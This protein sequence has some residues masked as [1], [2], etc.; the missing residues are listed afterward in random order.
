MQEEI[1]SVENLDIDDI[2]VQMDEVLDDLIQV[3]ERDG[4]NVVENRGNNRNNERAIQNNEDGDAGGNNAEDGDE[5]RNS[6]EDGV[7]SRND[8]EDGDEGRNNA[9]DGDESRNN[10]ESSEQALPNNDDVANLNNPAYG[11]GNAA[12]VN[13]RQGNFV[14]IIF[15][16]KKKL[17]RKLL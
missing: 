14:L 16:H 6:A 17:T 5:S 7:E 2:Q 1:I 15:A 8:G 10:G 4:D 12:N 3:L 13:M 9:E 11:S